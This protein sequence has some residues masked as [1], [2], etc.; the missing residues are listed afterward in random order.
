[1]FS[2][3]QTVSYMPLAKRRMLLLEY[4]QNDTWPELA[5][6]YVGPKQAVNK[7]KRPKSDTSV[8]KH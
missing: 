5:W 8:N 6:H 7:P 4:T 2:L 3:S 1:M